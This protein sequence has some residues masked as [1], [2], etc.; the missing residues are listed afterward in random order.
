MF[1]CDY[2][3][4]YY[5]S[6]YLVSIILVLVAHEPNNYCY[7]IYRFTKDFVTQEFCLMSYV[8]FKTVDLFN[9]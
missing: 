5:G 4:R 9:K 6:G 8:A 2:V 3:R 1:V 7:L